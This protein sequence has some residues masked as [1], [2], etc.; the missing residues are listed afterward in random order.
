LA[1][2]LSS[3]T[4]DSRGV[5]AVQPQDPA[6]HCACRLV[7]LPDDAADLAIAREERDFVHVLDHR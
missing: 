7:E 1:Q 2:L 5:F 4:P 6:G 3:L